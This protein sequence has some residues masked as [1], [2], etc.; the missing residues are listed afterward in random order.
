MVRTPGS[1]L[2][3]IVTLSVMAGCTSRENETLK[4]AFLTDIHIVPGSANAENL[5]LVVAEINSSDNELVVIAGDLS[6]AG[7]DDELYLV[8]SILDKLTLPYLIIPGNHET[9]WSESGG[10][11]ITDIWGDD[12]FIHEVN[13][14]LLVG[15]N[16]G[17]Y[18]KMS[19]G[20]VKQEDLQWLRNELESRRGKGR[21]LISIAHYPLADGLDNWFE[22]TDLLKEHNCLAAFCGHG[23]RLGLHNFDGILGIMGR[24]LMQGN[25]PA[26]GYNIVEIRNDSIFVS[27]KLLG[28]VEL[29]TVVSFNMN[30]PSVI[31]G[32]PV[33][34]RPDYSINDRYPGVAASFQWTDTSSILSGLCLVGDTMFI[35]GNSL[36]WV[37]AVNY[38]TNK[39]EWETKFEGS[40]FSTPAATSETVVFGSVDGSVYGLDIRSG[41]ISWKVD[42]GTP[43]IGSPV[44]VDNQVY[45]GGGNASFLSINA[46]IGDTNWAFDDIG[47]LIQGK[48][49]VSGD[50]V[51]FGAWDRH[52]YSVSA[53][54]GELQWKWNNGKINEL[55]SPGNI[56]PV[57]S[58][59]RV[60]IVA[61]DRFMT[62]IDL[63]TGTQQWRTGKHQVRE[64]MGISPDGREVFAKLMND[65]IVSVSA[66]TKDF[67]TNWA[68]DAGIKYEHNPCPLL[69]NE[70]LVI[71][72]TKNGL[73]TAINRKSQSVAWM[74]KTGNSSVNNVLF[75]DKENVWV[76]LTE[77]KIVRLSHK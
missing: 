13:G 65:S 19:D 73:I 26:A 69:V 71:G 23:H 34:P 28:S 75:D 77:G 39:T 44:I 22:V 52:L 20:H 59:N 70:N 55:F 45:I 9:N 62:A 25:P 66:L 4:F 43:V 42:V 5:A 24:A 35:Y 46:A 68:I 32:L 6:N 72:A 30:D 8:K 58:N 74:H 15:F 7:S 40:F 53:S 10:R 36:G 56:V 33:S 31:D 76:T 54:T 50:H 12:R 64:S 27:E 37:K 16:T 3:I 38:N 41:A 67:K 51:V 57:I 61:P 63:A 14:Y 47:G 49:A 48:P 60:F 18:M 21:K 1:L 29:N 2:I 11:T 17:P